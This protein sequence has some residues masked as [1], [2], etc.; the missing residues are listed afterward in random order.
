MHERMKVKE[1]DKSFPVETLFQRTIEA[2]ISELVADILLVYLR[3][4]RC[5]IPKNPRLQSG[6]V[7]SI[8]SAALA[9]DGGMPFNAGSGLLEDCC[10]CGRWRDGADQGGKAQSSL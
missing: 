9:N 2:L 10:D 6:V 7:H 1:T 3:L 4:N 8:N 5:K